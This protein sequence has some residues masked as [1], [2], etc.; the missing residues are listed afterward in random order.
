MLPNAEAAEKAQARII[1]EILSCFAGTWLHVLDRSSPGYAVLH[2]V[3]GAASITLSVDEADNKQF[4]VPAHPV[5]PTQLGQ[6]MALL[7]D[8]AHQRT[9]GRSPVLLEAVSL[10]K[11]F[12]DQQALERRF[13]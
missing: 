3:Q 4:V 6:C 9:T 10:T 8:T 5:R 12:G 2:P 7:T 13:V 11:R 1:D